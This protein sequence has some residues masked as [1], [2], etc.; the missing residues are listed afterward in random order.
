VNETGTVVPRSQRSAPLPAALP[1]VLP[2][3]LSLLVTGVADYVPDW[4]IALYIIKVLGLALT[5]ACFWRAY[6]EIQPAL[7][8]GVLIA[9]LIGLAVIAVWLS[10]DPYYPQSTAEFRSLLKDGWQA[11]PHAAKAAG[12]FDPGA[13]GDAFPPLLTIGSRVLGAVILVPIAE[14]LFFR[15]WLIRFLVKDEFKSV[16]MGTFTWPSFLVTTLVFGL[17]HHE[18]LAGI[19]CALAFNMLLYWRR[20]LFACIVA[21]AAANLGLAVWVLSRGAWQFW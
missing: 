6:A 12:Q 11:F 13:G 7:G 20:S 3:V 2:L 15:G 5:L 19:V 17:S 21:H 18:W 1:Y 9:V 4:R 10:I 8:F 16:P 14:E